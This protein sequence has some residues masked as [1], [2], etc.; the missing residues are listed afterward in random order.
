MRRSAFLL[1][2]VALV[3]ASASAHLGGLEI[4][5]PLWSVASGFIIGL[6]SLAVPART[7]WRF[8]LVPVLTATLVL[9][10]KLPGSD[11]STTVIGLLGYTLVFGGILLFQ[12]LAG[13]GIAILGAMSVKS[14]HTAC[15]KA[16]GAGSIA[17][18]E[19]VVKKSN[20]QSESK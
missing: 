18:A 3:P 6:V 7:R 15:S 12:F 14:I 10:W 11:S 8:V 17:R 2:I 4:S 16:V 13:F 5:I 9:V 1:S 19:L 20:S